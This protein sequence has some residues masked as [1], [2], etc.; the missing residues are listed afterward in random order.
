ML[1][2]TH[3]RHRFPIKTGNIFKAL[4]LYKTD[5]R[6]ETRCLRKLRDKRLDAG[7]KR[8]VFERQ[9]GN[10]KQSLPVRKRQKKGKARD[11]PLVLQPPHTDPLF[12]PLMKPHPSSQMMFASR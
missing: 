3:K 12:F 7:V 1:K 9:E 6:G 10:S 8:R 4:I 2:K 5:K 11:K